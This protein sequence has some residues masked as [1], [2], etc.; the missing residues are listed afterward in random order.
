MMRGAGSSRP[1]PGA[2]GIGSGAG[3]QAP[4]DVMSPDS[5]AGLHASDAA[6]AHTDGPAVPSDS[7]AATAP[8]NPRTAATDPAQ[9]STVQTPTGKAPSQPSSPAV[10]SLNASPVSHV[11]LKTSDRT[12]SSSSAAEITAHVGP[13]QGA[14]S[15]QRSADD[16][17]TAGAV[18]P[19]ERSR[20]LDRTDVVSDKAAAAQEGAPGISETTTE[21]KDNQGA[22][23]AQVEDT[24]DSI[25]SHPL[26]D[27]PGGAAGASD[28][29]ASVALVRQREQ[30]GMGNG[31]VTGRESRVG[32]DDSNSQ[33]ST[34]V[35]GTGK[36][37]AGPQQ[38]AS[39]S[40]PD[41]SLPTSGIPEMPP[42]LRQSRKPDLP[43]PKHDP[44]TDA[45]SAIAIAALAGAAAGIPPSG[46]ARGFRSRRRRRVRG[47]SNASN[48]VLSPPP[49][50]PALATP[51]P[52][53]STDSLVSIDPDDA[54]KDFTP[55]VVSSPPPPPV[56]PAAAPLSNGA[57]SSSQPEPQ[58]SGPPLEDP[59]EGLIHPF[60]LTLFA[61]LLFGA[62]AFAITVINFTTDMGW[63]WSAVKV[64]RKLAKSLAFRQ[65]I[66]LMVAIAFVRYGLEPLVR[67]VR[68]VFSLPGPWERSTEYFILKQVCYQLFRSGH[69]YFS[70]GS[71]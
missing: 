7:A 37:K 2:F 32:V 60:H 20:T 26:D 49:R 5:D 34:A 23:S 68:S 17:R 12:L 27:V 28:A 6:P 30:T 69:A 59:P 56:S 50:S 67:S 42:A 54:G 62:V 44:P 19:E 24:T 51:D 65:S 18:Q 31:S 66:A 58:L 45:A 43:R 48:G 13:G 46:L 41:S 3:L 70:P 39:P 8:A 53:Q 35:D 40:Q 36:P 4:V 57:Q 10:P 22:S 47:N 15:V 33:P 71:C 63:L 1:G 14:A 38:A 9:P 11:P 55:P 61:V 21:V 64:F 16:M 52:L 25:H 29:E